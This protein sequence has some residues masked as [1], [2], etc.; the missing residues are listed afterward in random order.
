MPVSED[1]PRLELV[2]SAPAM[3]ARAS[4]QKPPRRRRRR[5]IVAAAVL[6]L[7]VVGAALALMSQR[8]PSRGRT[9]EGRCAL[10]PQ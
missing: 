4:S 3:P 9:G 2:E 8:P 5:I 7:A 6:V 10:V 1:I